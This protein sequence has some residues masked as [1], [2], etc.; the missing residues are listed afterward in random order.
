MA[1]NVVSLK[2]YI[3]VWGTA[4]RELK[5]YIHVYTVCIYLHIRLLHI[6]ELDHVSS[7][8]PDHMFCMELGPAPWSRAQALSWYRM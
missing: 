6:V 4:A 5:Q 1:W 8:G 2:I 7:N 3:F